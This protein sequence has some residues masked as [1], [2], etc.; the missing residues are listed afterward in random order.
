[1][2]ASCDCPLLSVATSPL[3][4]FLLLTTCFPG[5]FRYIAEVVRLP[6]RL[7][8]ERRLARHDASGD[9]DVDAD[10]AAADAVVDENYHKWTIKYNA[11]LS[12][13]VDLRHEN[14]RVERLVIP[15]R[16]VGPGGSVVQGVGGVDVEDACRNCEGMLV[17]GGFFGCL[18]Y[19]SPSPRD[20][21]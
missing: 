17:S 12:E 5:S 6:E 10:D 9:E 11:E 16:L 2:S 19:T 4:Y 20:R 8:N 7:L 3:L 18:L 1:M 14:L 15:A 13:A 21:G